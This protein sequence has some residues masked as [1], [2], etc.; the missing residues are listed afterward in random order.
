M[1]KALERE[2]EMNRSFLDREREAILNSGSDTHTLNSMR[3][4]TSVDV[5]GDVL[6]KVLD[7]LSGDYFETIRWEEEMRIE[8]ESDT[9]RNA[10]RSTPAGQKN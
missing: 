3:L 6:S 8:F 1:R 5:L 4:S 10:R 2:L 7:I 9:E